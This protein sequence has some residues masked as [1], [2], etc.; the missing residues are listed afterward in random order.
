MFGSYC[1]KTFLTVTACG[2]ELSPNESK[3]NKHQSFKN[4]TT[5]IPWRLIQ[6]IWKQQLLLTNAGLHADVLWGEQVDMWSTVSQSEL[7]FWSVSPPAGRLECCCGRSSLWGTCRIPVR[8]TRRCWSSSPAEAGW[9]LPRAARGL[10]ESWGRNNKERSLGVKLE[11]FKS[12]VEAWILHS[13]TPLKGNWFNF[14]KV[15]PAS[16][17]RS[18]KEHKARKNQGRKIK[19][20]CQE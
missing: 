6:Q 18:K 8:P 2:S 19:L 16:Y 17:L 1:L 5:L 20:V 4:K 9:I 15:F 7:S 10:C 13:L 3:A 12:S 14:L 11:Q